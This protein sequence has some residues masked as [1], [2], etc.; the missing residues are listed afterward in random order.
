MSTD[1]DLTI[2]LTL[3]DRTPYTFRWMAYAESI[4]LPFKILIADGGADPEVSHALADRGRYPSLDYEYVRFP[5]DASYA[6]YYLKVV[7]A[8]GRVDTDYVAMA[9]NDD[10]V[11][12]RTLSQ[13]VKFLADNPDYAACGGRRAIFW[14]DNSAGG[15]NSRPYGDIQWKSSRDLQ[16]ID[17]ESARARILQQAACNCD[18]FY[19]VKRTAEARAEFAIVRE[20]CPDDLFLMENMVVLLCAIA[21]KIRRLDAFQNMRQ[22]NVPDSSGGEHQRR[23]G[24]WFGRMLVESWSQDFKGFLDATAAALSRVDG[25]SLIEARKRMR[26]AYRMAVAPALLS[27]LLDESTVTASMSIW[28]ALIRRL[29]GLPEASMLRKFL[30]HLYRRARWISAGA[31]H[32]TG[33]IAESIP[34]SAPDLAPIREF[35]SR[36]S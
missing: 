8:L 6:E 12:A 1:R 19:D 16:S 13:C 30:R 26:D 27:D 28:I 23:Y 24:D 2:L 4:R 9:D 5:Y 25:I 14:L 33:F 10:F 18:S 21:G 17:G 36:D 34:H 7:M 29:V 31:V 11:V 3:R 22:H 35:L 32:G 15:E 20:L